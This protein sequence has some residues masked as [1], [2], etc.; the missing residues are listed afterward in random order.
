MFK[1]KNINL[2]LFLTTILIVIGT[3]SLNVSTA[4]SIIEREPAIATEVNR[5]FNLTLKDK[6]LIAKRSGGRSG[7]GSF[8]SSP[9]RSSSSGSKSR[10]SGSSR[11]SSSP[12]Y[13]RSPNYNPSP[14]YRGSRGS[15]SS[16]ELPWFVAVIITIVFFLMFAGTIFLPIFLVYKLISTLLNRGNRTENK[17]NRERDNDRVTVSKLQIALS[18]QAD[19]IQKQLS[20]LSLRVDTNT[21]AGLLELMRESVLI[22][23]RH[24]RAWTHVLSSSDSLHISKAEVAFDK[25]SFA[26]RS[27]FSSETLSNVDGEVRTIETIEYDGGD[28]PAY[29]VV[30]LI[31]GTADDRPL[32]EKINTEKQLKEALLKLASMR[33][34]YLMKF[35]LLWTPQTEDRYL[36]DEELLMEYTDIIPLA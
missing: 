15:S 2:A 7:G 31:F 22:V 26:E 34:D 14:S 9:S 20:E 8:K 19:G 6:E 36:T 18:P 21:E 30:T 5:S 28:F 10:S 35:E 13:E 32:F 4:S 1:P 24:D 27:K 25:I 12:T 33:E 3:N 23:L 29:V 17:I 11:R 16:Q